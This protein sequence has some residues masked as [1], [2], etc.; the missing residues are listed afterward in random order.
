MEKLADLDVNSKDKHGRT[1]LLWAAGNGHEAVA[2]LLVE[3]DDVRRIRKRRTVGRPLSWAAANGH[4]AMVK[5][6]LK[7]SADIDSKDQ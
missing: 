7:K 3:R 2:K 5:L 1:A 6:P 4:E